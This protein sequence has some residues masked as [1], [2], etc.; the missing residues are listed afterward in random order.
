MHQVFFVLFQI[1][2]TREKCR[3]YDPNR[4]FY[5]CIDQNRSY[6]M[7]FAGLL[8]FVLLMQI[9]TPENALPKYGFFFSLCDLSSKG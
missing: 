2:T 4:D 3:T 6:L 1:M 8:H 5:I 9:V 7:A